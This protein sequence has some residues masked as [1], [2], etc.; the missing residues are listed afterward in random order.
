MCGHNRAVDAAQVKANKIAGIG[1]VLSIKHP[2]G[3]GAFQGGAQGTHGNRFVMVSQPV[4][5][6]LPVGC[7]DL[8]VLDVEKWR[9]G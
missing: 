1:F 3:N 9:N 4:G 7:G 8:R 2:A 5:H 6:A